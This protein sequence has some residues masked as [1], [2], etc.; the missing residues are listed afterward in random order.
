MN[1][2]SIGLIFLF[3]VFCV[4]V[5]YNEDN[6]P[7]IINIIAYITVVALIIGSIILAAYGFGSLF[8][9]A[10]DKLCGMYWED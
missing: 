9:E 4:Y 3:I 6:V 5:S 10:L 2:I 1:E 7:L 8:L